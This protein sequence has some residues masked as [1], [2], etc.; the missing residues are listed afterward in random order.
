M[1]FIPCCWYISY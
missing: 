1:G